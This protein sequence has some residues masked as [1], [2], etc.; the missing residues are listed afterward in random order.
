MLFNVIALLSCY[1]WGE[2]I[3]Y[4]PRVVCPTVSYEVAEVVCRSLHA[5]DGTITRIVPA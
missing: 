3:G 1:E 2:F 4:D 5:L